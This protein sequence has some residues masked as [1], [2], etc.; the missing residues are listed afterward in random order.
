MIKYTIEYYVLEKG[1][2]EPTGPFCYELELPPEG[3]LRQELKCFFEDG[4]EVNNR[5]YFEPFSLK[6]KV[7]SFPEW[8]DFELFPESFNPGRKPGPL[9]NRFLFD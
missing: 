4:V 5:I 6:V 1:L 8:Q 7:D 3:K 2:L 9:D